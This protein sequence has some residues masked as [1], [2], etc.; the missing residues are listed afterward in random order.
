MGGRARPGTLH[1]G[2]GALAFC[3]EG[4]RDTGDG[5]GAV[6]VFVLALVFLVPLLIGQL[7][8]LFFSLPGIAS[9]LDRDFRGLLRSLEENGTLPV[10]ADEVLSRIGQDLLGHVEALA[11]QLLTGLTGFV[12]SAFNLGVLLFGA[13]FV[14]IY[15]LVD[16]RRVEAAYPKVAPQRYHRDAG[17]LWR[18]L[19]VSLSRYLV[20]PRPDPRRPGRALGRSAVGLGGLL[21]CFWG[22]GPRLRS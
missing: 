8:D 22:R 4:P 3:A 10:T 1:P 11:R 7:G 20:R 21:P 19:D 16:A 2:E 18:A 14:A 15:L 13:V 5:L 17:K 6:R 9:N 12:S